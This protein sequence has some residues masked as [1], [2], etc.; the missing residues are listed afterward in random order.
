MGQFQSCSAGNFR[1]ILENL[2]MFYNNKK[3]LDEN[4]KK[5]EYKSQ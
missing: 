2:K 4:L 1:L 3:I 5:N